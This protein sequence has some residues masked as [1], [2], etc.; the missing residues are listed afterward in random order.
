MSV[1]NDSKCKLYL[2]VIDETIIDENLNK[3]ESDSFEWRAAGIRTQIQI[4][5]RETV[6]TVSIDI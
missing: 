1:T 2:H 4:S 3:F 6:V 5:E